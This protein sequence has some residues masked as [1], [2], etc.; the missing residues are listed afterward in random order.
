[1]TITSR[2]S[3]FALPGEDAGGAFEPRLARFVNALSAPVTRVAGPVDGE[4]AALDEG[5]MH[6]SETP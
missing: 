2:G 6:E 4:A 5:S 3:A 1:M